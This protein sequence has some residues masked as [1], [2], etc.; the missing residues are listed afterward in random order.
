MRHHD[1]A[2]TGIDRGLGR[3]HGHDRPGTDEEVVRIEVG[4]QSADRGQAASAV[5]RD[6]ERADPAAAR[7]LAI[8]RPSR[9][10]V[11]IAGSCASVA[12]A[13]RVSIVG[14]NEPQLRR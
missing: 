8:T 2:R 10:G 13:G 3:V 6:L 9:M 12:E 1:E 14:M 11:G 7:P 5:E 4:G